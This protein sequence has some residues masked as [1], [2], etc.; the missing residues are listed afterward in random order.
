MAK[1]RKDDDTMA[2]VRALFKDSGFSLVELGRRIGYPEE[3]ARQSAWQ[4]MRTTDPR[5][6]M[7]RKFAQ[8]MGI[9]LDQVTLRRRRMSR[10]LE[11]EL[12]Q[13]GCALTPSAFR[14]LIEDMKAATSPAWTIDDLVCH[15]DEAKAFCETIRLKTSC[16]G[17]A[18]DLILR[19]LMNVRRSH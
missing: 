19:T 13:C 16:S 8:A 3:T 1:K 4:F 12:E 14:E 5:V 10:K 2:R 6:S 15:P 18:D 11:E 9:G 7:L 17:M